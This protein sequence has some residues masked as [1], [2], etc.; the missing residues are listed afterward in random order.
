MGWYLDYLEGKDA[1]RME[2]EVLNHVR[3]VE[4]NKYDPEKAHGMEDDLH[5]AVL[6]E[7]AK[8]AKNA[9]QLAKLA[10]KTC[11]IEFPRRCA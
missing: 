7:I 6:A 10:L 9:Q 3:E 5:R 4:E 8:G 11:D 2:K 1:P